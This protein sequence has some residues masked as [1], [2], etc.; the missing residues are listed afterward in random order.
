MSTPQPPSSSFVKD[1]VDTTAPVGQFLTGF[2]FIVAIIICVILIGIAI[3]LFFYRAKDNHH[4]QSVNATVIKANCNRYNNQNNQQNISCD[5][6]LEYIVGSDKF[7]T[8]FRSSSEYSVGQTISIYYDPSNPHDISQESPS[9]DRILAGILLGFGLLIVG[10]AYF[11]YWLSQKYP[12]FAS[13]E[14][15]ATGVGMIGN[16]LR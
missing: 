10:F 9:A 16:A 13:F 1:Y 5:L 12:V 3:Y 7:Q 14:T 4:T 15:T 2:R 11:S 8:P 6:T